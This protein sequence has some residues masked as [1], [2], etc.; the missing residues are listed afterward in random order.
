MVS[1]EPE[2]EFKVLSYPKKFVPEIDRLIS[3]YYKNVPRE[4]VKRKRIPTKPTL[5]KSVKPTNISNG[6]T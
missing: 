2:G 5:E 4:V 1:K 3:E 6:N